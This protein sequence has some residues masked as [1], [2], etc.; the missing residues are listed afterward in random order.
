MT[1]PDQFLTGKQ[2]IAYLGISRATFHRWRQRTA[3]WL[4]RRRWLREELDELR[5]GAS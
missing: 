3:A 2:A 5:A 4:K 1:E